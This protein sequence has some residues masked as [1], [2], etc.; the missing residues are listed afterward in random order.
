MVVV[1]SPGGVLPHGGGRGPYP[2]R[3]V[4]RFLGHGSV[5]G[6]PPF[7]LLVR[8]LTGRYLGAIG[9]LEARRWQ[10]ASTAIEREL[11]EVAL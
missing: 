8:P 5:E 10:T 6:F 2:G 1:S 11:G 3:G 7:P 4:G 9:K